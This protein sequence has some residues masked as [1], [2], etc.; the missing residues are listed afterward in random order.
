MDN[1]VA[2]V[3]LKH[4][5]LEMLFIIGVIIPFIFLVIGLLLSVHKIPFLSFVA[6]VH[7]VVLI[8]FSKFLIRYFK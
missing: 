6:F 3:Q 7:L 4:F 1:P 5:F 8:A 2:P